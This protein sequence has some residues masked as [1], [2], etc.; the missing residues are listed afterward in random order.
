MSCLLR[1]LKWPKTGLRE[2]RVI[3]QFSDVFRHRPKTGLWPR[4][5]GFTLL[6]YLANF[7][8]FSFAIMVVKL[9]CSAKQYLPIRDAISSTIVKNGSIERCLFRCYTF[10]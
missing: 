7:V 8:L 1:G 10:K 5:G 2:N 6:L 9:S 3:A 4:T